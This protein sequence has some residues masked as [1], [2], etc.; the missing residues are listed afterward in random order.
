MSYLNRLSQNVTADANNSSTSNLASGAIFT[1][2]A[3]STLGIVGIQVSLKTDQ[4]CTIYV[5]QA[6]SNSLVNGKGTVAANNSTTLTGTGTEFLKEVNVGDTIVFD[7]AGT[8]QTK[9]V[10]SITSNTV[11]D[12]T[13]AFTGGSLSGKTYQHYPWDISDTYNYYASINNFGITVQAI[14]SYL[15]IRV[16]N[17]GSATTSYLRLQ[18]ALCPIVEAVPRSLNSDGNLKTSINGIFDEYGFAVEN[19]PQGEIRV[20]EPVRL[21]GTSY[22]GNTIDTNFITSGASGT[23]ASISQ[24]GGNLIVASGTQSGAVVYAYTN[25]KARY[26]GGAANRYRSIKRMDAGTANNTRRWGVSLVSNYLLTISSASVVAGDVYTNNTQMFTILKT[27]TTTTASA[28]GTGNPGAGAQTYTRVSGG[29]PAT[30]T[31]SNFASQFV[32]TDGAWFQISGTTFSIV[33]AIGGSETVVSSGSF[34]GSIGATYTLGTTA[35][36]YEIYYV[37]ASIYFV[38]DGKL[39]HKVTSNTANWANSKTFHAFTDSSNSNT[40]TSTTSY[41]RS[42]TIYRLGKINS[43]KKYANI[44]TAATTILKYGAGRLY[45]FIVNNNNQNNGT[46]TIYDGIGAAGYVIATILATKSSSANSPQGVNYDIPFYNGLTV[47]NDSTQNITIT[48]E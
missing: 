31:G 3:T 36:T 28:Y 16:K 14:N 17:I 46:I 12:V 32:V 43:E 11:L 42:A 15:R 1:G 34:N 48:Y 9:V 38:I 18:T 22:E 4:N 2:T 30:L 6:P 35:I 13:V 45:D 20:V 33:T 23:G 21:V 41:S 7:S 25:R 8:P 5:D 47:V 40:A 37:N 26:L 24:S 39:L 10:A 29:G 44:T 19:T 27:E